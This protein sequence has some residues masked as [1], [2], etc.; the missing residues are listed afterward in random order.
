MP[1]CRT[2]CCT[3][4]RPTNPQQIKASG[5]WTVSVKRVSSRCVSESYLPEWFRCF[6]GRG[7]SSATEPRRCASSSS[8]NQSLSARQPPMIESI[9]IIRIIY[10][11]KMNDAS[12][13][14]VTDTCARQSSQHIA[15]TAIRNPIIQYE[16]VYIINTLSETATISA[17]NN[18]M[19][20]TCKQPNMNFVE[21]SSNRKQWSKIHGIRKLIPMVK[22]FFRKNKER[23]E[24]LKH[25]V[26]RK[27]LTNSV[28]NR[29]RFLDVSAN[30]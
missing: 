6:P 12:A 14:W 10:L 4:C 30:Q 21:Q 13:S 19:I 29:Q 26:R 3:T 20:L 2:A 17:V 1:R 11:R 5:A 7:F 8:T 16:S 27:C 25:Y 22:I 9:I 24:L 18:V 15:P 23:T 28:N